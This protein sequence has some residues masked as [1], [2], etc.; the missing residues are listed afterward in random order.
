[1]SIFQKESWV[2]NQPLS[3]SDQSKILIFSLLLAPSVVFGVGAIPALFII[4][5]IF[6]LKKNEDFS[7]IETAVKNSKAYISLLLF[8]CIIATIYFGSTYGNPDH[9]SEYSGTWINQNDFIV[10]LIF[11][12]I[13][14]TYIILISFLFFK[15]LNSHRGWVEANGIFSSKNKS[16]IIN[17][18]SSDVDIIKGEKLKQYSV[19]D[20]LTKWAKLK[21]DG[22]IS[23]E[24]FSEARTKLLKRN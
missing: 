24:E 4:F 6:M 21:E 20:E 2:T 22:H 8:G 12:G 10:S 7:H 1:M 3:S 13:A 14:L 5:G 23:E 19:A 16:S 15:P 18:K 9:Y 17:S 11:T